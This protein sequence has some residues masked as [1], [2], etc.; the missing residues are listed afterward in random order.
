[1]AETYTV[2]GSFAAPKIRVGQEWVFTSRACAF[3]SL[4]HVGAEVRFPPGAAGMIVEYRRNVAGDWTDWVSIGTTTDGDDRLLVVAPVAIAPG[5][6]YSVQLRGTAPSVG[7][8][9]FTHVWL[10][11]ESEPDEA[12][13][14][15]VVLQ[16]TAITN[17]PA[18]DL[19]EEVGVSCLGS[20]QYEAR[21]VA[22][23]TKFRPAHQ[24]GDELQ[25]YSGNWSRLLNGTS[26]AS[27][28][29][30]MRNRDGSNRECCET[31]RAIDPLR[32]E[33]EIY[34]NGKLVWAGPIW[35][36]K[37]EPKQNEVEITAK[38]LSVWWQL[39]FLLQDFIS[40]GED[41]AGIFEKY[42]KYTTSLDDYGLDVETLP[43]GILG[44]RTV[45]GTSILSSSNELQE[46]A[47]TGVDWT[48]AN[49]TC[50][51]GGITINGQ[52][53]TIPT[54][55]TDESFTD[56]PTT[57]KTAAGMGNDAYLKGRTVVG[58]YVDPALIAPDGVL[59][60]VKKT[61]YSV[62][63][64]NSADAGAKSMWDRSHEP[65]TYLEG[66]NA[67]D[68]KAEIDIQEL[69]CGVLV[70]IDISG[71]GCVP[72]ATKLRLERVAVNFQPNTEEVSVYLQPVGSVAD[73]G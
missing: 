71:G 38:D 45:D 3:P 50:F 67:L 21:I 42:V 63:D 69:V 19:T 46:L 64:Q 37:A 65:L 29:I 17:A 24:I 34:R 9:E 15:S 6:C 57:R 8:Y 18:F 62:E 26:E 20:G 32:H 54:L 35:D 11:T 58:H 30:T 66:D 4:V 2:S 14:Q 5:Q 12:H 36:V 7:A 56:P 40:R 47:R 51:V 27:L 68:P 43:C 55:L 39:R 61:E 22:R 52:N 25:P 13:G 33:L 41:L 59:I 31:V 1:M 16:T 60:Q 72:L 73:D 28:R 49:R 44:D 53:Y 48:L 23:K 10:R 70:P